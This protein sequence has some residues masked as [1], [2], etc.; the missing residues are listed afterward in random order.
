VSVFLTEF[1]R[2]SR[3]EGR[4]GCGEEGTE[5]TVGRASRCLGIHSGELNPLAWKRVG[6][7]KQV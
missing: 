6:W 1:K 5:S 7:K 3:V 4:A 2:V